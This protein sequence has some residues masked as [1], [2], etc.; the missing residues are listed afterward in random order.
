MTRKTKWKYFA[1]LTLMVFLC[2]GYAFAQEV[3][4]QATIHLIGVQPFVVPEFTIN[5]ETFYNA[6]RDGKP[7]KLPFRDLK[8][9]AFLNPGKSLE[10]EVIFNDGRKATYR[11]QPA[12]DITIDDGMIS[13]YSHSKVARIQLAPMPTRPSP[14]V[15]QQP[16][17]G[18]A[19]VIADQVILRNGD[20]LSGQIQTKSFPVRTAYGTFQ[21]EA[22]QIASIEFDATKQ[23]AAAVLL[24]NGDRLSGTVELE[25][26]RFTLMSGEAASFDGK[27]IKTITFK[28]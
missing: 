3:K 17:P 9:I 19:S 7:V 1:I 20:S 5:G 13:E 16:N 25:S 28:R 4:F 11:L 26:L 10:A 18:A 12:A 14:P 2:A 22:A 27:S 23:A 8:E 21:L 15:A 6:V 24:K